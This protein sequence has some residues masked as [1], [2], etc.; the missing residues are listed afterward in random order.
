MPVSP[1][2]TLSGIPPLYTI[3][4]VVILAAFIVLRKDTTV[5]VLDVLV[6]IMAGSLPAPPTEIAATTP[7]RFPIPTRV[8]VDTISVCKEDSDQ[9]YIFNKSMP[10]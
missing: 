3:S 10:A 4:F 7:T 2:V 8:A 9:A 1:S 5:K 6:P